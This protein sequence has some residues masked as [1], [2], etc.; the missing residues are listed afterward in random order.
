MATPAGERMAAAQAHTDRVCQ[1]LLSP[2][3]EQLDR[4]T[5]LLA[6]AVSEM[7]VCRDA[8]ADP[9]RSRDPEILAETRRL[10]GSVR[11]AQRLLSG[12]AAF[13]ADWIRCLGGLCAGYT[14]HGEPAAVEL[15]PRRVW[16]RG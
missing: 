1:M 10:Q 15:G 16:A 6:A 11:L 2:S 4:C 14:V 5:E 7:T 3:P 9:I 13:H 8:A 12:A